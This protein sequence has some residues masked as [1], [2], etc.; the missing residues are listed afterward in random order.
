VHGNV[1]DVRGGEYCLGKL[2]WAFRSI[3]VGETT[4]ATDKDTVVRARPVGQGN[5]MKTA[6]GGGVGLGHL[7]ARIRTYE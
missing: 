5:K 7:H 3:S 6:G 4:F 1:R 2:G